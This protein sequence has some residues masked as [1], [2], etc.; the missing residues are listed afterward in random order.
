MD[1]D[2]F[3]YFTAVAHSG[4]VRKAADLLGVHPS[5]VT[6]RLDQFERRLGVRLFTRT[7]SGLRIT[8]SGSEVI[9]EVDEVAAELSGIQRR[10]QYRLGDMA[11]HLRITIDD[12]F[13]ENLLTHDFAEFSRRYPEVQL[14]FV[15]AYQNPDLD[16]HQVDLAIRLTDEPPDHLVGRRLGKYTAAVY[17]SC[18]YLKDHE[19]WTE[20]QA[21]SWIETDLDA[22][23]LEPPVKMRHFATMPDGTRSG[24]LRLQLAAI[25]GDL[26]IGLIPCAVGDP[27]PELK[28]LPGIESLELQDVWMLIHPDLRNLVRLQALQEFL[29]RTFR[30]HRERL[31]GEAAE[32]TNTNMT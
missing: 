24:S 26:G 8:P 32:S 12:L 29:Q 6:R 15:A 5:T 20:P 14:E 13:A 17:G 31:L 2:D 22:G 3:K 30:E 9:Q 18:R 19:P 21:C 27:D 25:R 10:L 11:G 23:T 16:R 1:W 7:P 4:S 28:R